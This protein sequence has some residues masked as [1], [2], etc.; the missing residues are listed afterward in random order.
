MTETVKTELKP[1]V[2]AIADELRKSAKLEEGKVTFDKEVFEKTL[3]EG[4]TNKLVRQAE[5]HKQNFGLAQSLVTGELAIPAMA[6]NKELKEVVASTALPVGKAVSVI[7]REQV[8]RNVAT[9]QETTK[10]GY[11]STRIVTKV[12]GSG[13]LALRARLAEVAKK[14]GLDK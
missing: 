3:P 11:A 4:L 6:K 2:L 5:H 8:I 9:G 14:E 13:V 1:E 12:P 10:Y 7:T